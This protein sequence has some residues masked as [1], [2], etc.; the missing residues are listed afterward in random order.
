MDSVFAAA[1]TSGILSGSLKMTGYNFPDISMAYQS[2]TMSINM[3][4]YQAVVLCLYAV[5]DTWP[6]Q[7]VWLFSGLSIT[8]GIPYCEPNREST[9]VA[10]FLS[11]T[12]TC[13]ASGVTRRANWEKYSTTPTYRMIGSVIA[14]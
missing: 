13:T 2:N 3:S 11:T 7:M 12:F 14:I 6:S 10:T 9:P 8:M 1:V 4:S 5:H